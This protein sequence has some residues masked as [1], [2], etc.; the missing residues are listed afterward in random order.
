MPDHLDPGA[1][2]KNKRSGSVVVIWLLY[3]VTV[4]ESSGLARLRAT[5]YLST[6]IYA[7]Y[8]SIN[9]Y[10]LP[11]IW[12]SKYFWEQYNPVPLLYRSITLPKRRNVRRVQEDYEEM[13]A[14]QTH[15][16][17]VKRQR[18]EQQS[19]VLKLES[20]SPRKRAVSLIPKSI[21]QE[22]YI[23]LLLDPEKIIVFATGP[24]G[25]GKT[26]LAV[27]AALKAYKEGL[28][29]KIIITRPAVG[30]DDEK[31][32]F[33]PG[34]L[35]EKMEPWTRPIF[36][37]MKE[38]YSPREIAFMLEE[39]TIEISPLA[40]LRG[41]TFKRAWIIADEMQNTS[42]NTMK[43]LLTRIG[44]DSKMVLTGD[45]TQHDRLTSKDNGLGDFVLRLESQKKNSGIS[46]INF[47]GKD[48]QR[49]PIV[50][51]VLEM[52]GEI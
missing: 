42:V 3:R 50:S 41:R 30:V 29:E 12:I 38:Y 26:M 23:D 16:R 11:I 33:L 6:R 27:L 36:D 4:L 46:L 1:P 51:E 13:G 14:P 9:V 44:D 17:G 43:M 7:G 15:N 52:Y 35:N 37:V 8:Q 20:F 18:P 32:G 40:Y 24:A 49:H 25:T 45:L 21:K 34:T 48:I 5:W 10:A 22:E 39:E 31:H 47:S 28:I 2:V 19:N